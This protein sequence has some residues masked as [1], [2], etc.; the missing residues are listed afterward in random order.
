MNTKI[1]LTITTCASLF[2]LA[3]VMSSPP[4][5]ANHIVTI[6]GTAH[7]AASYYRDGDKLSLV[8]AEKQ[9]SIFEIGEGTTVEIKEVVR[10]E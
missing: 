5:W 10:E 3:C 1:V 4:P 2:L 8:T 9:V 6:D 7:Y